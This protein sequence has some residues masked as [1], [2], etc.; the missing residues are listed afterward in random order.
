MGSLKNILTHCQDNEK[1]YEKYGIVSRD[2][3]RNK[4]WI[5]CCEFFFR[6]FTLTEKTITEER[7]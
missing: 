4:G 7:E 6:N 2:R 1:E 5:E 3:D